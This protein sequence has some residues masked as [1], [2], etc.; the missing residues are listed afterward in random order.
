MLE[1][2][3]MAV[4]LFAQHEKILWLLCLKTTKNHNNQNKTPIKATKL[5]LNYVDTE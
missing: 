1:K 4:F 2:S 3:G 5:V